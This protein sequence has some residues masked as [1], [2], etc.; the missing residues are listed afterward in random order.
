MATATRVAKKQVNGIEDLFTSPGCS[1]GCYYKYDVGTGKY[2]LDTTKSSCSGAGCAG[3]STTMPMVMFELVKEAGPL[4]F[5]DPFNVSLSCGAHKE[6]LVEK[7]L[8]TYVGC[9]KLQ[10]R[11]KLAWYCCAGLGIVSV[12][13]LGG[14]LYLMFR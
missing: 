1:G 3:C 12:G 11:L 2:V 7:L 14:V 13:L 6:I 8:T 10:K 9:L 4:A 5:P